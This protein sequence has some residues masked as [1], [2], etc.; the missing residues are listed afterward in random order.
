[1]IIFYVKVPGE[2][3]SSG[4]NVMVDTL[5]ENRARTE[6]TTILE[7]LGVDQGGY[8]VL[9]LHHPSNVDNIVMFGWLL[10]ALEVIQDE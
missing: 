7:D 5:L 3:D 4:G 6:Q 10:D 1:M 9:T 2:K 8:A